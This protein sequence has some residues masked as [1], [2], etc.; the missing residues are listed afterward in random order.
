MICSISGFFI[1]TIFEDLP[2]FGILTPEIVHVL[3]IDF[4]TENLHESFNGSSGLTKLDDEMKHNVSSVNL[5]LKVFETVK[6]P[7]N[8]TH[9]YLKFMIQLS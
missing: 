5:K 4:L 8:I 3:P 9:Y 7:S 1:V 2:D 6:I